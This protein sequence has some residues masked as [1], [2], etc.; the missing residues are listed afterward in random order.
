MME[1]EEKKKQRERERERGR[2]SDDGNGRKILCGLTLSLPHL[3]TYHT[4]G[5][6]SVSSN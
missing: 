1:K 6:T 3:F 2:C 4:I 5:M